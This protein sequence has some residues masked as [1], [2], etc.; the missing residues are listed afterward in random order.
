MKNNEMTKP[1]LTAALTGFAQF[2]RRRGLNVGVEETFAALRALDLGVLKDKAMF[3]YSLRSL[4][5]SGKDDLPV[6]DKI[7]K[8][9]WETKADDTPGQFSIQVK[10]QQ[11]LPKHNVLTVWGKGDNEKVRELDSKTVTGSNAIARLRRTDFSQVQDMDAAMLEELAER[12]WREMLK[13]LKRRRRQATHRRQVDLR[14]TI[15]GSLGQGGDPIQL[16]FRDKRPKKLRLIVLLDVSGSM[17]KY[18]FFLLRYVLALQS[19]FEE[20]ES[21]IFS[22]H[23]RRI[24]EM[25][26][27]GGLGKTLHLLSTQANNWSGGTRIGDCL[28]DFNENYA[29]S[30]LS[31]SA[32]VIVLSDGLDTG[33][34]GTLEVEVQK[35]HR[36]TKRLIWLNPLKG[37]AGYAPE[38]RGMKEALPHL[39]AF[40]PAHNL[41][42]LLDLEN[43]LATV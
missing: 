28:R 17:D 42:S 24:T 11:N 41:E 36:R 22:T 34:A 39:D 32:C 27:T 20:V 40:R 26:K 13:R 15:R 21:F 8:I 16:Y 5:C 37:M 1:T 43:L 6:F 12:L 19:Y 30:L 33:E 14:R 18:S 31:R 7:F 29:K 38:A 2:A 23:L 9:Y 10:D 3:Y 35:I 4:F 25:L